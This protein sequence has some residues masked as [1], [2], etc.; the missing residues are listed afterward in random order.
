MCAFFVCVSVGVGAVREVTVP[1]PITIPQ[2]W[3]KT[4][5]P[6]NCCIQC[7][8]DGDA[9]YRQAPLLLRDLWLI[10]MMMLLNHLTTFACFLVGSSTSQQHA[11]KGKRRIRPG[12]F[13]SCH[14]ETEVADE[15]C[16]LTQLQYT[17]TGPTSLSA[18]PLTPAA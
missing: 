14:T 5:H 9:D 6:D 3:P 11:H 17:D 7:S 18:D 2:V 12:N 8:G 4:C 10:M 13:T 1:I 15:T 16:N